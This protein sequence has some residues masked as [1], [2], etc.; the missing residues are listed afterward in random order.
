MRGGTQKILHESR[1]KRVTVN[2]EWF[3][4]HL[5][6]CALQ[7]GVETRLK[8]IERKWVERNEGCTD[9]N[10]LIS[11]FQRLDH[12]INVF[13]VFF[14]RSNNSCVMDVYH[15]FIYFHTDTKKCHFKCL[16]HNL[17]TF[18]SNTPRSLP[19]YS[20]SRQLKIRRIRPSCIVTKC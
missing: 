18:L 5:S 4:F 12:I 8:G 13:I 2:P 16:S 20:P 19:R 10:M 6:C 7:R 9:L 11:F 14:S 3:F 1:G 15:T 17:K